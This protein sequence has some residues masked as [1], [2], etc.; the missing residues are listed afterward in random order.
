MG[1][2][3]QRKIP[4]LVRASVANNAPWGW[5][6][7]RHH[8]AYTGRSPQTSPTQLD[9]PDAAITL[10]TLGA[11]SV[12]H[13]SQTAPASTDA[14]GVE[15]RPEASDYTEG[16]GRRAACE[17]MVT[18]PLC[19]RESASSVAQ[20]LQRV[21]KPSN[22]QPLPHALPSSEEKDTAPLKKARL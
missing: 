22:K 1:L 17:P 4:L 12:I 21:P 19:S 15:E 3:K 13:K 18:A 11:A 10:A 8:E 7:A 2:S 5:S 20:L 16:S 14:L 6:A 9:T